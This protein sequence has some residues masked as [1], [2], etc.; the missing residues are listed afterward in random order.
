MSYSS[1]TTSLTRARSRGFFQL[2]RQR[3][4]SHI[5]PPRLRLPS[6]ESMNYSQPVFLPHSRPTHS[7]TR[8]R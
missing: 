8:L 6:S 7:L 1:N 3:S 2:S 4:V 5:D